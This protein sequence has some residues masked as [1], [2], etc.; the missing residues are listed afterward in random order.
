MFTLRSNQPTRKPH[1]VS[2]TDMPAV[3]TD[4]SDKHKPDYRR[5]NAGQAQATVSE[6]SRA[7][8][9]CPAGRGPGSPAD[10]RGRNRPP[11]TRASSPSFAVRCQEVRSRNFPTDTATWSCLNKERIRAFTSRSDDAES[12]SIVW[13][14][15]P[16]HADDCGDNMSATPLPGIRSRCRR[17]PHFRK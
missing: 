8:R 1:G 12:S 5:R 15:Y 2:G 7:T 16:A 14:T 10:A 11:P 6:R 9:R 17:S 3:R 13:L 4:N